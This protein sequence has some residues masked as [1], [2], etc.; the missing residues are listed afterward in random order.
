MGGGPAFVTSV[1]VGYLF[2]WWIVT[3]GGGGGSKK[4]QISVTSFMNDP[5][6]PTRNW[7]KPVLFYLGVLKIGVRALVVCR[8]AHVACR[9]SHVAWRWFASHRLGRLWND[10]SW[11]G[12]WRSPGSGCHC[13]W[14]GSQFGEWAFSNVVRGQNGLSA[15]PSSPQPTPPLPSLFCIRCTLSFKLWR[16]RGA[17]RFEASKQNYFS[18]F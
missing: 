4:L 12:N 16:F 9:R 15:F 2:L 18:C 11:S 13:H 3:E 7:Y 1:L 6:Q 14:W 8:R 5:L 17:V 10:W